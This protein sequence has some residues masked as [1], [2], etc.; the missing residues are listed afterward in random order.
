LSRQIGGLSTRALSLPT[1]VAAIVG[2]ILVSGAAQANSEYQVQGLGIPSGGTASAALAINGTGDAVGYAMVGGS[3]EGL[4]FSGGSYSITLSPGGTNW[5]NTAINDSGQIAGYGTDSSGNNTAFLVSGGNISNLGS[6]SG[7][8]GNPVSQGFGIDSAGDV[9]GNSGTNAGTTHAFL[10]PAGGTMADLGT[11]GGS[12][13]YAAGI[14]A[15]GQY[16]VGYSSTSQ[17][18]N[19][20]FIYSTVSSATSDLGTLG[21]SAS[22]A[23]AVNNSGHVAGYS[24]TLSGGDPHAFLYNGTTMEDLGDPNNLG[25][26]ATAIN[27]SDAVVGYYAVAGGGTLAFVDSGG[28]MSALNS[29]L[30]ANPGWNLEAATGIND[31]G[32]IVGYGTNPNGQTEAFELTPIPEPATLALL[33]APGALMLLARRRRRA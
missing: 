27:G 22:Y 30:A 7:P 19:H 16:I 17:G 18:Q 31:S 21:G 5:V 29:L 14:S 24:L 8:L 32:D 1:V 15:N 23:A 9:V 33:A 6:L 13:S 26:Y 28:T 20:A 10:N 12:S 2:G 11:L 4:L 25:S 3:S